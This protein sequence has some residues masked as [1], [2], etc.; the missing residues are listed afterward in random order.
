MHSGG[1][2]LSGGGTAG[3]GVF[4]NA[5]SRDLIGLWPLAAAALW[6]TVCAMEDTRKHL[7]SSQSTL[8]HGALVGVDLTGP[9]TRQDNS[10]SLCTA[11]QG[12]GSKHNQ[13]GPQPCFILGRTLKDW[14]S[15][16]FM[17]SAF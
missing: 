6:K 1:P 8:D 5:S 16:G 4:S 2:S 7:K 13:N 17:M 9:S 14:S 15:D 10:D 11:L 12:R 3:P